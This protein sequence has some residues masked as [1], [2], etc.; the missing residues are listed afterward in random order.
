MIRNAAAVILTSEYLIPY[1]QKRYGLPHYAVIHLRPLKTNVQFALPTEKPPGKHLVYAGGD[2]GWEGRTGLYGY[3]AYHKIFAAFIEAG[4]TV[5]LYPASWAPANT[6][7]YEEMGVKVHGRLPYPDLLKEMSVY[8]AGLQGFN[9]EGVP[10][11][12]AAYTQHYCVPNKCFDYLAAGIPTIGV[13]PGRCAEIYTKGKWGVV[14]KEL[15]ADAIHELEGRLPIV[16]EAMRQA[17]VMDHDLPKLKSLVRY[18]L[19]RTRRRKRAV[20]TVLDNVNQTKGDGSMGNMILRVKSGFAIPRVVKIAFDKSVRFN[21]DGE[22]PEDVGK[23]F[24]KNLPTLFEL[25]VGKPDLKKYTRLDVGT[26]TAETAAPGLD[27]TEEETALV[28]AHRK[29][30]EEAKKAAETPAPSTPVPPPRVARPQA[31]A[32]AKK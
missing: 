28:L 23:R 25:P 17:Q 6:V 11:A 24:L 29:K 18:A 27:L 5:H 15:S 4:W 20:V 31:K 14:L 30:Q 21:P 7:G 1:L 12:A 26:A 8:T 3:R 2:V 13:N 32:T 9:L 22:V 16:T 19:E 10:P